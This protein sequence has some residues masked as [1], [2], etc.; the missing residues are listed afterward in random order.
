MPH[1]RCLLT[2]AWVFHR[3]SIILISSVAFITFVS[4]NS[5]GCAI[6]P[7]RSIVTSFSLSVA[8]ACYLKSEKNNRNDWIQKNKISSFI[9]C[10]G[11]I[12]HGIYLCMFPHLLGFQN[13]LR[14]IFHNDHLWCCLCMADHKLL[15]SQGP[16]NCYGHYTGTLK[17]DAMFKF[18]SQTFLYWKNN[19]GKKVKV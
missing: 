4:Y 14:H 7:S 19:W 5:F 16:N 1:K 17:I 9:W 12:S 11:I 3:V 13:I 15:D 18:T 10:P 6:A 2:K 8:F